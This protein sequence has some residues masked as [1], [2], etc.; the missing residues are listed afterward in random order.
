M[1]KH[2]PIV[3]VIMPV[4]NASKYLPESIESI[5]NQSFA[6]FEFIIVDD[7]STDSS[8]S[9]IKAY[10]KKDKRI[11]AIKNPINLGVSLTSNIALSKVKGKFLVRMDADDISFADRIEKELNFL[12]SNSDV[13]AVGSQCI[14]IDENNRVIGNKKFP[15][16]SEKLA[17]MIFWAI[18]MQQPSIMVN[19]QKLPKKFQWYAPNLSSAED[20]NLMFRFMRYGNIANLP[21]YLLFYRHLN[22][23][24]SHKNPKHTF[25]LT[26]QSRLNAIQM[27]FQPTIKAVLLNFCQVMAINLLP[28]NTINDLWYKVRGITETDNSEFKVGTWVNAGVKSN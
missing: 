17:E 6:D 1:L 12:K 21:E 10:A 22:N 28:G 20:V 25:K 8:W 7:A 4:F 15:T 16:Q 18:P 19:L 5:L 26:M 24:L 9:V 11:I 3:S 23:S 13:V 2:K 27:G 14:V